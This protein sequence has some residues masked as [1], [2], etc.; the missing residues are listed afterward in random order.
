LIRTPDAVLA[1]FL[2]AEGSWKSATDALPREADFADRRDARTIRRRRTARRKR[3]RM[4]S[5]RRE[6]CVRSF[7]LR[8]ALAGCATLVVSAAAVADTE[9]IAPPAPTFE[10]SPFLGYR[11]GGKFTDAATNDSVS[12]DAHASYAIALDARA[13]EA[14]QYEFFYSRQATSLSGSNFAPTG[15]KIEYLHIGGTVTLDQ[16]QPRVQPYLAGG[17]GATLLVPDTPGSRQ[18]TAFSMSLALGLRIPLSRHFLLRVEGRGYL[19]LL[20]A[21]TAIFCRS[22]QSGGLCTIHAQGSALFQFDFLAGASFVF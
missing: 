1:A 14:A 5:V 11:V 10:I 15:L 13:E 3:E 7:A 16:S 20:N 8:G 19:T 18:D 4:T 21:D 12:V 6:D 22:D 9:P 2:A 17:L